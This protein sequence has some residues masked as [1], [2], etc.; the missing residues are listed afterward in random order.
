MMEQQLEQ[1]VRRAVASDVDL[2]ESTV[3][4]AIRLLSA[5]PPGG[6]RVF[7]SRLLRQQH[8]TLYLC[9]PGTDLEG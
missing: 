1:R 3:T 6:R 9:H 8:R 2:L 5:S 7:G 4:Y